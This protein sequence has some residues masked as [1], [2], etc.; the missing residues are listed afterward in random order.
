MRNYERPEQRSNIRVQI[1]TDLRLVMFD[2]IA[3]GVLSGAEQLKLRAAVICDLST[4]GMRIFT[5]DLIDAWFNA[6]LAGQIQVAAKFCLPG[7]AAAVNAAA[8]VMWVEPNKPG[9]DYAYVMGLRF[10]E[11]STADRDRITKFV[12]SHKLDRKDKK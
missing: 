9:S 8:K 3:A 2:T 10:V 6:M 4:S 12:L 7:D 5:N 11:L 1:Q